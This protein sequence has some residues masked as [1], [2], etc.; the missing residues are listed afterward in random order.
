[1]FN[2]LSLNQRIA[3]AFEK[4][5]GEENVI[6]TSPVMGGEDF[7]R[8]GRTKEKIPIMMFWLG[9]VEQEK[10]EA[11]QRGEIQ[12]PSLHNSKFKPDPQ[13]TIK[14]GVTAM[15]TGLFELLNN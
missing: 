6:Q 11:A 1:M 8:Y 5:L 4:E 9:A 3:S 2:D 15:T 13:P 12:L 10:Y 7:G 14:T